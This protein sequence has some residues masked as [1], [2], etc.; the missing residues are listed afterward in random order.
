MADPACIDCKFFVKP[1]WWTRFRQDV[2]AEKCAH[3]HGANPVDG[4]PAPC[5]TMRIIRCEHGQL[6]Q[7]K[8]QP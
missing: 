2:F 4:G 5:V 8:V 6:F 7:P 1:T 3:P